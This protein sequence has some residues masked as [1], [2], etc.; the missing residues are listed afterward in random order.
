MNTKKMNI[1][2]DILEN[3]KQDFNKLSIHPLQ[4]WEWGE[5]RKKTGIKVIRRGRVENKKLVESYQLTLHKI[6]HTKFN[7]GYLPKGNIPSENMLNDLDQIGKENN[8]IFIQLEPNIEKLQMLNDQYQINQNLE[9]IIGHWSLPQ[10]THPLFTKHTL[11]LD[12][13]KTEEEFLKSFSQKTRYNIKL[14]AK[15]GIYIKEELNQNS[16]NIYWEIMQKTTTRQK[17]YAHTKKY[18]DLMFQT[19]SAENERFDRNELQAHLFIGYY[20]P[21]KDPILQANQAKDNQPLPLVAWI[22]FTFKD[23]LYYPYGSSSSE[24]KNLMASN[25]MMWE[26]IKFGKKLNLKSFDMWGSLGEN[27][28][29][30]DPWYGFHKFK[31]GYNPKLV[32]F[33]GSY[34]LVINKNL[35]QIY[36]IADKLRKVY[37]KIK[38]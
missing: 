26:A 19:L 11:V 16:F 29:P 38:K 6:P 31:L 15:H 30:G 36:K 1:F 27:P 25:L 10:S 17:F 33:I 32:E 13:N 2:Q 4:T 9:L 20:N 12:L 22:L 3:Q 24:Y 35:Y 8:C 37:L 18:H 34:D 28:D 23:T 14:A 5:F 7:I 21:S